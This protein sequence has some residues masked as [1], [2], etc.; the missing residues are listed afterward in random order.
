MHWSNIFVSD[1]VRNPAPPEEVVAD[2]KMKFRML[3]HGMKDLLLFIIEA[4]WPN[5]WQFSDPSI[6]ILDGVRTG[7][8]LLVRNSS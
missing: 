5:A 2:W 6:D 8:T 4:A 1:L 7:R 3:A